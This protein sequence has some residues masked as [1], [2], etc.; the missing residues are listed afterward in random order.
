[1]LFSK[2]KENKENKGKEEGRDDSKESSL[3]SIYYT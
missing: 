1:M 2:R 3:P